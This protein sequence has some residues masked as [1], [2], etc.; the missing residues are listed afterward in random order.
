[1]D[2]VTPAV[3]SSGAVSP[4]TRE[5]ESMMP[6]VMPAMDV[7]STTFTIVSHFGTPSAYDASRSSFGTSR[8]IS[9]V[10]AH[11]DR[12]HQHRQR[13]RAHDAHADA[14]AEEDREQGVGEQTRDDRRDAGHDVDEE[15]D[16]AREA[17]APRRTRR[18]RSR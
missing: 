2:A 16:A 6:V 5:I 9:S 15:G 4:M 14:G 11:D 12:D 13:D 17:R 10:D 8:S 18:G 7:G 1:M 3:M